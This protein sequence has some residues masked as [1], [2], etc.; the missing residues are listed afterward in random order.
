MGSTSTPTLAAPTLPLSDARFAPTSSPGPDVQEV[1]RPGAA[2]PV[3]PNVG[4]ALPHVEGRA[5]PY[6]GHMVQVT[7]GA[8]DSQDNSHNQ[9]MSLARSPART[10]LSGPQPPPKRQRTE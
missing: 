6:G 9:S 3:P 2:G 7:N 4:P 10:P 5:R 1:P 8:Q